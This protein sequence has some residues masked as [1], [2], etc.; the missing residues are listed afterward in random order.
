MDFFE[1]LSKTVAQGID[2]AKFEADKFQKISRIQGELNEIKRTLDS[3]MIDLGFRAYDLYRAGQISS[4]SV[5]ELV[6]AIDELRS[7]LVVK[8]DALKEAQ[9][10]IYEEPEVPEKPPATQT[11][12]IEKEP[13][14]LHQGPPPPP[15][16]TGT[17]ACPACG[18]QMPLRARFCPRCGHHV[19][20]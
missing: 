7:H 19:G 17:K 12:M 1:K 10:V 6:E 8:E 15:P 2:R 14:S 13:P 18:F 3:T 9:A 20:N 16:A 5:A 4:A 11:I